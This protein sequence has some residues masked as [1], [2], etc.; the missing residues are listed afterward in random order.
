MILCGL[1]GK[2]V[3]SLQRQQNAAVAAM[4]VSHSFHPRKKR[5]I[6]QLI[7]TVRGLE[8]KKRFVVFERRVN[9]LRHCCMIGY[10]TNGF[11]H[12]PKLA[13]GAAA[14]VW[15]GSIFF[16]LSSSTGSPSHPDLVLVRH[17]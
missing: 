3:V 9:L 12:R 5:T 6:C 4:A 11:H 13:D 1:V 2:F 8:I 10:N 16:W 7:L 15:S 14:R 17:Y